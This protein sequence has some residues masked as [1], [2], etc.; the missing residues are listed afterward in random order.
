[1]CADFTLV[2]RYMINI[3]KCSG[4]YSKKNVKQAEKRKYSPDYNGS[5]H[6]AKNKFVLEITDNKKS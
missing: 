5:L 4:K 2:F 1:M 3:Y 6:K